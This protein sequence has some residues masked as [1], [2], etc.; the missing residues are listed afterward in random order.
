[1]S[2]YFCGC[3]YRCQSARHSLAIIPSFHKTSKSNFCAIQLITD[4]ESFH[5][6]FPSSSLQKQN[7][8]FI[9]AENRFSKKGIQ[10]DI[11]MPELCVNGSLRFGAFTPIRYDIMGPFRYVP[12]MQCYHRV[13][14]M[15][16]S[17]NGKISI[18]NTTYAFQNAA[19]YIE[20]DK[21]RSFPKEYIWTQC[22][23]P[24]GAVM[25]SIADIPLGSLHFT[26]VIGIIYLN[27]VEYRLA[28]YLGAKAIKIT[29]E[30]IIVRQG[31]CSLIVN[32]QDI[33]G[34]PLQAPIGGAMIRTIHEH[35]S[36]SVNYRFEKNG[37]TILELNVPNAAFEYE[38]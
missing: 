38:Y 37:I 12:F 13:Y 4:T 33:S 18:N 32:P 25:L 26:G 2:N 6:E 24:N 29:S 34:H 35:P 23:F 1:M 21:G 3:Y 30:E 11:K 10:L 27:G 31:N 9:I 5:I 36:C 19:G 16:H 22:S 7:D 20:G 17:V 8:W 15:K 14:S 28:T